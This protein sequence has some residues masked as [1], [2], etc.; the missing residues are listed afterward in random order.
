MLKKIKCVQ[1]F[2]FKMAFILPYFL[3]VTF[4]AHKKKENSTVHCNLHEIDIFNITV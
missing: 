4:S 1:G 2:T 3:F